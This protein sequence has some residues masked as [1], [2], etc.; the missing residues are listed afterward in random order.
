MSSQY[1]TEAYLQKQVEEH[2]AL[3]IGRVMLDLAFGSGH[4]SARVMSAIA[5][6]DYVNN[7]RI[8]V[9]VRFG[10]KRMINGK[11]VI[12]SEQRK[13]FTVDFESPTYDTSGSGIFKSGP[14]HILTDGR[15]STGEYTTVD[16][17]TSNPIEHE[18]EKTV[19]ESESSSI[20]LS[21]SLEL[22]SGT[23]VEAGTDTA[24]V[25]QALEVT[26][27]ISKESTKDHS[28]TIGET[29]TDK[30]KVDLDEKL[31]VSYNES[32]V[33]VDQ[34][35]DI[36]SPIDWAKITIT[37]RELGYDSG[38]NSPYLFAKVNDKLWSK[39]AG[40]LW[41]FHVGGWIQ[42]GSLVRGYD[43][44]APLIKRWHEGHVSADARAALSIMETAEL[45]RVIFK[46]VRRSNNNKSASYAAYVVT[47]WDGQK[48]DDVFGNAGTPIG[49]LDKLAKRK[50]HVNKIDKLRGIDNQ[51]NDSL[52]ELAKRI[53][54]A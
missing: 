12:T 16:N 20:S 33:T 25:S 17:Q 30:L 18:I 36:A 27:G 5:D 7:G 31:T 35:V 1:V 51:V 53:N 44:R 11:L 46:G 29:I 39:K 24:K 14:P 4:D 49:E 43:V 3:Q 54:V 8:N 42:F 50:I 19:E 34:P 21:E 22:K 13:W 28:S 23:T 38:P 47:G 40:T 10:L 32:R 15:V 26:L 6:P 41:S 52:D 9:S 45:R 48:I 37:T 2:A